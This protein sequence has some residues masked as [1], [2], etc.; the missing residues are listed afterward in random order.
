MTWTWSAAS[1]FGVAG[2]ALIFLFGV[3]IVRVRPR[4]RAASWVAGFAV[5]FG[6]ATGFINLVAASPARG[7][8]TDLMAASAGVAN[9]ATA[10]CLL[11]MWIELPGRV[12][13][14]WTSYVVPLAVLASGLFLWTFP[15]LIGWVQSSTLSAFPRTALLYFA[16]HGL[17][18][19][20][21]WGLLWL[22]SLRYARAD[23]PQGE[24]LLAAA[25]VFY[26][27]SD[28][29]Y[30]FASDPAIA[31][32]S[33][34][35]LGL[36]FATAAAWLV[37][38]HRSGRIRPARNV[39][40]LALTVCLVALVEGA[41]SGAGFGAG[42]GLNGIARIATVGLLS[43]AVVRHHVLGLDVKLRWTLSK[44][45]LAAV[46]VAVFFVAS[47]S[48]Q[49]FFGDRFE[50]SY[51]GI[52]AAGALVFALAPLSRVADRLAEKAVPV[53][54]AARPHASDGDRR[55]EVFLKAAR[56]ALRGGLSRDEE[57]HL[58]ELAEE[59]G[60]GAGRAAAMLREVE[61]ERAGVA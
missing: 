26:P 34:I 41:M 36:A 3:L 47:E 10:L 43:Y 46:F 40:W 48:A 13:L 5:S 28:T 57:V 45:T 31:A 11:A 8:A 4:T 17:Q 56:L 44:S 51:L 32:F 33:W 27:A 18:A 54:V 22:L 38:G 29:R 9:V 20:A 23:P 50:S 2:A 30:V 24:P 53:T 25:L 52:L 60:I 14:P 7:A 16:G 42:I 6:L 37:A 61:G 59:L 1:V 35:S 21:W 19:G 58:A 55:E 39:A 15:L 12:R 49:Q